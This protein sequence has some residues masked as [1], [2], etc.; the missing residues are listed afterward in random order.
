MRNGEVGTLG[1]NGLLHFHDLCD[2]IAARS[3][4]LTPDPFVNAGQ[5]F[6]VQVVAVVDCTQ[7]ANEIF[8]LHSLL[9]LNDEKIN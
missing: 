1:N 6:N 2:V 7:V 3:K 8:Q 4:L 5:H 9:R